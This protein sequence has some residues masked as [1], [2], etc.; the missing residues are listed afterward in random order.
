M[1]QKLDSLKTDVAS[2]LAAISQVGRA[3]RLSLG[4]QSVAQPRVLNSN[5][6]LCKG[7]QRSRLMPLCP[8]L[9]AGGQAHQCPVAHPAGVSAGDFFIS[10]ES[11]PAVVDLDQK[12]GQGG[13][14]PPELRHDERNV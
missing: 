2:E 1:G 11:E 9:H 12:Q 14:P 13:L 10:P 6:G 5:W 8:T 7:L 3:A 4:S